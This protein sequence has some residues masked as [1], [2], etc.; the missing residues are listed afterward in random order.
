MIHNRRPH[1]K[2]KSWQLSTGKHVPNR[3][4]SRA[5]HVRARHRAIDLDPSRPLMGAQKFWKERTRSIKVSYTATS[6]RCRIGAKCAGGARGGPV[7]SRARGACTWARVQ[8]GTGLACPFLA[9][10]RDRAVRLCTVQYVPRSVAAEAVQ[11]RRR[12]DVWSA[13]NACHAGS[14]H[15]FKGGRRRPGSPCPLAAGLNAGFAIERAAG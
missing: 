15:E 2:A 4:R 13:G 5:A 6:C 14:L 1:D 7:A 9:G 11:V 10:I 8:I 3:R 12:W